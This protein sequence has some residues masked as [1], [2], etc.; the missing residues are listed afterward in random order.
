MIWRHPSKKRLR[1]WL[2]AEHAEVSAL[3]DHLARC[4]RCSN[5]LETMARAESDGLIRLALVEVL[6]PPPGL[7]E[8]V[9]TKVVERLDSR[10]VFG[11]MADLFGA[12]LD[13][14][15][16]LTVDDGPA[17]PRETLE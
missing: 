12:G 11:F 15:R 10:Q 8:R 3:D 1:E 17:E 13:T 6:S 14:V 16:L 9:E 2:S 4:V 7:S 5:E